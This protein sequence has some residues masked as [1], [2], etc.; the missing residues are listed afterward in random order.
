MKN[1]HVQLKS[2]TESQ[3]VFWF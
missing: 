2:I 3:F 1:S